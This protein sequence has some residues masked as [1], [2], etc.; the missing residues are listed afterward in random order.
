MSEERLDTVIRGA[1]IY[2]GGGGRPYAADVGIRGERIAAVGQV[3]EG[4]GLVVD[5]SGLA[6]APGFI[7]VHSHDDFAVLLQPDMDFKVMQG[8]TTDVVG[9]CGMGSAPF[10]PAAAFAQAFHPGCELERWEGYAGYLGA[11]DRDPPA[12]NVAVLV[13]H[14]TVRSAALENPRGEPDAREL[15]RM[16]ELLREGLEAGAVGFSTGLI[17]EPGRYSRTPELVALAREMAGSGGLYATH[18]RDEGAGLLDSIR[19]TLEIGGSGGVPVQVSHHKAAGRE[20]WGLV[21]RS[22]S[23]I[24]EARAGGLDVTADQYPYTAG[25]TILAAVVQ[26][27]NLAEAT[28]A[29]VD[30]SVAAGVVIAS[31]PGHPE[32]E[33]RSLWDLSQ[34]WG[35]GS[36]EAA[37]RVLEEEP[38]APQHH[39]RL[40]RHSHPYRQ[41]T[42]SPVRDLRPRARTLRAGAQAARPGGW[43]SPH[44]RPPGP[45]VPPGRPRRDPGGRLCRPGALRSGAHR[46]RRELHRAASL[47]RGDRLGVRERHRRG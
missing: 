31:T 33:G 15:D 46:R 10:E 19:E 18:M 25:S 37:R 23:L 22:L 32:Y 42:P 3:G 4:A 16:R 28:R 13:G 20:N 1:A 21:E 36:V 35:I 44:D 39:D 47:P 30:E 8:V 27:P 17:Y 29:G 7:D 38:A 45:Q 5:G 26:N 24:D 34:E 6:L 9:N 14:G 41:A 11:I 40:R 43:R 12:L 2:D